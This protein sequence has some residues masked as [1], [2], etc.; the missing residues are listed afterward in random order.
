M[1]IE[2][3]IKQNKTKIRQ[4]ITQ[5]VD[6]ET[7]KDIEQDVYLKIWRTSSQNK[8][9]GYVK[10]IVINTCKD[11]FKSKHYRQAKITS[12]EDECLLSVKDN[13][14]TPHQRTERMFRQKI[15]VNAINRLSPKL[16]EVIILYD[17]EEMEQEKI[18]AK[19]N[20]PVGTVKSRLFNARKQLQVDL[21]NL[22][23]G[24]FL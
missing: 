24:D 12:G 7:S 10:T 3:Y 21:S 18:A 9:F 13:A 19:L 6:N 20:C 4:V 11:F 16:K 22:T 15:I 23:E 14:E 5:Y 8:S 2:D 17:I 1:K